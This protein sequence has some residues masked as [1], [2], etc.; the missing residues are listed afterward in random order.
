MPGTDAAYGAVPDLRRALP[1]APQ[2]GTAPLS[3]YAP[4]A[5]RLRP[6]RTSCIISLRARAKILTPPS[7]LLILIILLLLQTLT[8]YH[9]RHR[10]HHHQH[11]TRGVQGR[12]RTL[13]EPFL[14][15]PSL[16]GPVVA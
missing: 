14:F 6:S 12:D 10:H 9:R 13:E 3:A 1:H 11:L 8:H 2:P 15:L 16:E 4:S 7:S 5:I